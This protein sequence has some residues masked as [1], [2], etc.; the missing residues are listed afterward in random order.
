MNRTSARILYLIVIFVLT[1]AACTPKATATTAPPTAEPPT[2]VPTQPPTLAP[3]LPTNTEAVAPSP[4]LVTFDLSGPPMKVGSTY[5]YVDGSILVA[6]PAGPFTMGHGGQDNP[7]HIVTLSDFWIFRSEVSNKQFAF[8]VAAGK[9]APPDPA[10]DNKYGDPLRVNEPITGVNWDQADAYCKFVNGRLPTEAEWEKTARGPDGNIYPWGDAAPN[11]DLANVGRCQ[12]R[13]VNVVDYPAG[14]S[15]YEALN[16][17]GNVL[18]WVS[19]WYSPLTTV[20]HRRIILSAPIREVSVRCVP[21]PTNRIPTWPRRRDVGASS[22]SRR[23]KTSA[24]AVWWWTPPP[25]RRG[26]RGSR[27]LARTRAGARKFR[28]RSPHRTVPK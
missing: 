22:L 3:I 6:V 28:T 10:T 27:T 16:L 7:E 8:C 20:F 11:C 25:S 23:T 2:L 5:L 24:S 4:T 15:Y 1:L 13:P 21:P 14:K 19:D 12:P 9:C 18:E 26:A 17:S